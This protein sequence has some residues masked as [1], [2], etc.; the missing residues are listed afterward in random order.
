MFFSSATSIGFSLSFWRPFRFFSCRV[1]LFFLHDQTKLGAD[2]R[3][4][5][6]DF[7]G[8]AWNGPEKRRGM[9]E[10]ERPR[11]LLSSVFFPL[12]SL[13]ALLFRSFLLP[14][15]PPFLA[16]FKTENQGPNLGGLFGRQSGTIE[17]FSYS[18]ANKEKAVQW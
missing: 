11:R 4:G 10:S 5:R 15:S 18:K 6:V 7:G 14:C 9:S 16:L 1:P 8:R 2:F 12:I 3:V 13:V 17:G